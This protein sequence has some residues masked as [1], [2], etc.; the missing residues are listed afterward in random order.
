MVAASMDGGG[1]GACGGGSRWRWC[2][3][4]AH[5]RCGGIQLFNWMRKMNGADRIYGAERTVPSAARMC[6]CMGKMVPVPDL[7]NSVDSSG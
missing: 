5:G 7:S 4:L 1:E 6:S 3:K 2:W